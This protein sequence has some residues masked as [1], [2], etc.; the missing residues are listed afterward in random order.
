VSGV[1]VDGYGWPERDM[2]SVSGTTAFE[3]RIGQRDRFLEQ[4]RFAPIIIT[5]LGT[6][7]FSGQSELEEL[8]AKFGATYFGLI[9]LHM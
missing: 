3:T 6:A 1:P 8:E 4:R 7:H 5:R 9:N 2:L